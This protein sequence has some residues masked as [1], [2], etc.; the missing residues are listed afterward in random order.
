MELPEL[1]AQQKAAVQYVNGPLLVLAGAGSG[2]TSVIT[3]KI[4]WLIRNYGISP[5][6]IVAVTLT[7]KAAR[8]MKSRV[9]DLLNNGHSKEVHISTFHVLGLR[10]LRDHLDLIGYRPGFS[11]YGSDDGQ[12]LLAKLLRGQHG[13]KKCP[14][15]ALQQQISIWK[16]NLVSPAKAPLTAGGDNIQDLAAWVYGEYERH[17]LVYNAMDLDDLILK[18]VRLF[19][20]HPQV[21]QAWRERVRY[22]LVDEYQDTNHVQHELV[23]LLAGEH[24]TMTLVGDD[25]QSIYPWHG[26]NPENM[27]RLQQEYPALKLIKLEQN[28]RSNGRILKAT[29]SLIANNTHL[30]EKAL[31]CE[32]DYGE[33]L[34][35]LKARSDDHE[36]ER[37]VSEMLYHK[38]KNS[39]DFHD[40]AFLFRENHQSLALER[41][42]RER[43]IPYYV[44]GGN[45]F[46]DKTEIKDVMAYLRLLCNPSDDNAFLRV[47]NTPRRDIGPDSLEQL[48]THAA[49]LGT[50][51]LQASLD[52]GIDKRLPERQVSTLR[53]F[54]LW[55]T[56]MIGKS[57]K[58][59]PAKLLCD[60]L[61][62]MHYEAWLKD[63]C[64]DLKIALRRMENVLELVARIQHLARQGDDKSLSGILV[65]LTLAGLLDQSHDENPGDFV[66]LM[67][68]TASKGHE[69][70]HVYLIGMEDG[71]LP[72]RQNLS[73]SGLQQERRLAYVGMTRARKTLTFSYTTR[74]KRGGEVIASEPSR[75]LKELPTDDLRWE[76]PESEADPQAMLGRAEVYLAQLRGSPD[77]R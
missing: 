77:R 13:G 36:A 19:Q 65:R 54:S 52:S 44:S 8:E 35:V 59:T 33:P 11:I 20:N 61:V 48:A 47:I 5:R 64:N 29:N 50:S 27:Q 21:L 4:A 58:E 24:A 16:N 22:L 76:E 42:L 57:T 55:L 37:I 9:A 70:C 49:E 26:V 56:E 63:I 75:F 39:T 40:Y 66:S 30:H 62:D 74:R 67:P 14:A 53:T 51:M 71:L 3:Q 17:L 60:M 18:P 73:E 41:V 25:D 46:F 72:H 43:R 31:W 12:A 38:F 15:K 23:K 32:S 2:K 34:R 6:H 68:L 7:N 10:I 1:N 69:F 45:S 28:Y